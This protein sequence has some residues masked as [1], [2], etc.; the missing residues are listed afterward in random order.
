MT[1][2]A[3]TAVFYHQKR[4]HFYDEFKLR[5]PPKL[6]PKHHLLFTIK[7][8]NFQQK[9]QDQNPEVIVG[10]AALPLFSK[11]SIIVTDGEHTL[12]VFVNL[13]NEYLENESELKVKIFHVT[14]KILVV[15][16]QKGTNCGVDKVGK[17]DL[18]SRSVS[19]QIF[20]HF[21]NEENRCTSC[22]R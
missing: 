18:Y 20:Y 10:Y 22:K 15:G 19:F 7:H 16:K 14:K 12:P 5:L 13:S 4:P 11:G 6:T 21:W 2:S 8:M 3:H 9:K 17:Y 1:K